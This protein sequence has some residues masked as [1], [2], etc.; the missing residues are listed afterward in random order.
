M[1]KKIYSNNRE[2]KGKRVGESRKREREAAEKMPQPLSPQ[3]SGADNWSHQVSRSPEHRLPALAVA[4]LTRAGFGGEQMAGEVASD[5][6]PS[7]FS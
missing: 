2:G 4:K 7:P 1:I 6:A 5:L 3:G